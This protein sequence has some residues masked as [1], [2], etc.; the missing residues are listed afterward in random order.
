MPEKAVKAKWCALD[1]NLDDTLAS[2]P[3]FWLNKQNNASQTLIDWILADTVTGSVPLKQAISL[4]SLLDALELSTPRHWITK[5]IEPSEEG[6]KNYFDKNRARLVSKIVEKPWFDDVKFYEMLPANVPLTGSLLQTPIKRGS[7]ILQNPV[8]PNV[9]E[10]VQARSV[11]DAWKEKFGDDFKTV[12]NAYLLGGE[13]EPDELELISQ[14]QTPATLI[15]I[16]M[17][18]QGEYKINVKDTEAQ[19]LKTIL[20]TLQLSTIDQLIQKKILPTSESLMK[21]LQDNSLQLKQTLI[22]K[23]LIKMS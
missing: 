21:Y 7:L 19:F 22:Q 13:I 20:T 9:Q 10:P 14:L 8:P 5:E 2:Q 15:N 4:S 16:I 17:K 11:T 18:N 3:R 1:Y 6:L 12:H 23:G